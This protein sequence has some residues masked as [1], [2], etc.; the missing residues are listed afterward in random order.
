MTA[1]S[2]AREAA[3]WREPLPLMWP[4]NLHGVGQSRM[5]LGAHMPEWQR[6]P[7]F[8]ISFMRKGLVV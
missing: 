1:V 6:S 8:R 4:M 5:N 2:S 7:R 3:R